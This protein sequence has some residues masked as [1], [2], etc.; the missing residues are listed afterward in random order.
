MGVGVSYLSKLLNLGQIVLWLE[1]LSPSSTQIS[2][3]YRNKNSLCLS[4]RT[5][6]QSD[7]VR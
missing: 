6:Q 5:G 3:V 7:A 1:T 4:V 2:G